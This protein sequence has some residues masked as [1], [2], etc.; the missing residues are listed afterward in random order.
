MPEGRFLFEQFPASMST[1]LHYR[2][3][4]SGCRWSWSRILTSGSVR[5]G[6]QNQSH[7]LMNVPFARF[8]HFLV[9]SL[10]RVYLY[11]V[12]RWDAV[13]KSVER[14]ARC[15]ITS[16]IVKIV[17]CDTTNLKSLLHRTR[18]FKFILF[19]FVSTS[20]ASCLVYLCH[21]TN[22][23]FW[24]LSSDCMLPW[25]GR[26]IFTVLKDVS[27]ESCLYL[28]SLDFFLSLGLF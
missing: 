13:V 3:F 27:S 8:L 2:Y 20:L 19:H 17:S 14:E 4:C 9:E 5:W 21:I 28:T 16:S 6:Q 23:L 26:L 1:C 25:L 11:D 12:D 18:I 7:S 15:E 24:R 22:L 10:C